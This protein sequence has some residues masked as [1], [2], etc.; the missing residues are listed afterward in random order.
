MDLELQTRYVCT[1]SNEFEKYVRESLPNLP[2]LS[3]WD[4]RESKAMRVEETK[5]LGRR[6]RPEKYVVCHKQITYATTKYCSSPYTIL[7][8]TID[9]YLRTSQDWLAKRTDDGG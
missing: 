7:T 6:W 1:L 2:I 5:L 3:I 8:H 9:C 4:G